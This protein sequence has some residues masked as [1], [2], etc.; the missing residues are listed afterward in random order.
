MWGGGGCACI[1]VVVNIFRL[2][3]YMY[4]DEYV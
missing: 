3:I 4:I 1:P 2:M